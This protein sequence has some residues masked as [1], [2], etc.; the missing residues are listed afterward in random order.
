MSR[1]FR[2]LL[3]KVTI[4]LPLQNS[5]TTWT[6]RKAKNIN[7]GRPIR[8][9]ILQRVGRLIPKGHIIRSGTIQPPLLLVTGALEMRHQ[10]GSPLPAVKAGVNREERVQQPVLSLLRL[11]R[12][13]H[14]P[15]ALPLLRP[16]R[17]AVLHLLRLPVS[18][19]V[20]IQN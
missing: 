17:L 6:G 12:L 5:P 18:F 3:T 4:G 15:A 7:N 8:T 13:L 2:S 10:L 19:S 1:V 9:H 20:S 11:L 14:L 16:L